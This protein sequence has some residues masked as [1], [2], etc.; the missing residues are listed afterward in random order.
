VRTS[1]YFVVLGLLALS[2]D[3]DDETN[4]L[5]NRGYA[6][7]MLQEDRPESFCNPIDLPAE[8]SLFVLVDF[9]QC[10][11]DTSGVRMSCSATRDG[12]T[13]TVS[14]EATGVPD[15]TGS[16]ENCAANSLETVCNLEPLPAGTYELRY[17]N[18]SFA[19]DIPSTT[20][21]VCAAGSDPGINGRRPPQCCDTDEDCGGNLCEQSSCEAAAP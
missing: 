18:L 14:A 3:D 10:P 1:R 5:R 11:Y 16:S 4:T 8:E 19:F 6:C 21:E 20:A 13:I 17:G 15:G 12:S 7:L 9:Q 2:C